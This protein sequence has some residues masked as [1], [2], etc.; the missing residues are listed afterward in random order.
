M[1]N[2]Q[3]RLVREKP[4]TVR[5]PTVSVLER[6]KGR[7]APPPSTEPDY[8]PDGSVKAVGA[9]AVM[10]AMNGGGMRYVPTPTGGGGDD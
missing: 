1:L 6:A 10:K 9:V 8:R 5:R 4:L 7:P 2:T 3:P